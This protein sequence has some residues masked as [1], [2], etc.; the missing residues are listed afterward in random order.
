MMETKLRFDI[1]NAN[2]KAKNIV[3]YYFIARHAYCGF[4]I[5]TVSMYETSI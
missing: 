2:I 4:R 3:I 1:L 5:N